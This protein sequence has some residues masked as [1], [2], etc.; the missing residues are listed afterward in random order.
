MTE[1][2]Q[3]PR[4]NQS[5]RPNK[6]DA[7]AITAP[8]RQSGTDTDSG[9]VGPPPA[10]GAI[11]GWGSSIVAGRYRVQRLLGK[12]GMGEVYCA[13]DQ[14]L[15]TDVV[16][17]VPKREL[18]ADQ[19]TGDRFERE[20]RSLVRLSHPHVVRIMDVGRH[21][22]LPFAVM[23]FLEG[24]SLED[25]RPRLA[26]GGHAPLGPVAAIGRW[27]EQI[28]KALDF[29]HQS[30]FLHRDVKP[31]NILFDRNGNAYL[32]DFGVV[33]FVNEAEQ[34]TDASDLTTT[35]SA[36]GTAPYLAPEVLLGKGATPAA[37]QYALAVTVFELVGGRKPFVADTRDRAIFSRLGQP[38]P[39]LSLVHKSVPPRLAQAIAKALAFDPANR[40]PSCEA[41][42]EE[43]LNAMPIGEPAVTAPGNSTF[44]CPCCNQLLEAGPELAA[45]PF[46]CPH[47]SKVLVAQPRLVWLEPAAKEPA[48]IRQRYEELVVADHGGRTVRCPACL[49]D[50][51][52][53]AGVAGKGGCPSC[54]ATLRLSADGLTAELLSPQPR[55]AVAAAPIPFV[56]SVPMPASPSEHVAW[57]PGNF[58]ATPQSGIP[59]FVKKGDSRH[60]R[61]RHDQERRRKEKT[62]MI[63]G[64]GSLILLAFVGYLVLLAFGGR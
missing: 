54:E 21:N 8:I 22:G 53:A 30:N 11:S 51:C 1:N 41:F 19:A 49:V 39:D 24:G 50:I 10:A 59:D 63:L 9:R 36:I 16:L 55:P 44:A 38:A 6:I 17:K 60:K 34:Q 2:Q 48:L 20:I 40:F 31:G 3:P 57:Q 12:G 26:A 52:V 64:V 43:L 62:E 13:F 42:A 25:R 56:P 61:R 18:V 58:D 28:G 35:G 27:V 47:C 37:D 7:D 23:P 14:N 32:S 46:S 15:K 33:K 5:N 4:P 45:Q 29:V